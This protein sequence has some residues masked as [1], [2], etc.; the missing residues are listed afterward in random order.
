M[1][2]S[3]DSVTGALSLSFMSRSP[4][5]KEMTRFTNWTRFGSCWGHLPLKAGQ[6]SPN[7]RGMNLLNRK[8]PFPAVFVRPSRSLCT[9]P[10]VRPKNNVKTDFLSRYLSPAALDLVQALLEYNPANRITAT[11]ALDTPF[12]TAE[13]P[14][15]ELPKCVNSGLLLKI[16]MLTFAFLSLVWLIW[17][18]NGTNTNRNANVS[19]RRGKR[20]GN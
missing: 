18:V 8:R 19:E 3:L 2:R 14:E 5:F 1:T 7:C 12:F 10:F 11:N 6:A 17:T 20:N 9:Y 13:T 16:I 15:K 4:S